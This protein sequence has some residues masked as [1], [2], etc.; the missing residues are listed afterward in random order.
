[1]DFAFLNGPA[2]AACALICRFDSFS[3]CHIPLASL[4]VS[5]SLRPPA[6]VFKIYTPAL[7]NGSAVFA[8]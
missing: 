4:L 6:C 1:M 5:F 2:L 7:F 3:L 8:R